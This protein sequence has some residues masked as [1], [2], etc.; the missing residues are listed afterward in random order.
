MRNLDKQAGGVEG[1][2]PRGGRACS[3]A[4]LQLKKTPTSTTFTET[5]VRYFRVGISVHR[6]IFPHPNLTTKRKTNRGKPE[7][8]LPT[9]LHASDLAACT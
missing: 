4:A 1:C 7:E 3:E 9:A 5:S 2:H 8:G 6:G